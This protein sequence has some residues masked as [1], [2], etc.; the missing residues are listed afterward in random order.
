MVSG[1]GE[2]LADHCYESSAV[3]YYIYFLGKT[4]MMELFNA[5]QYAKGFPFNVTV[6]TLCT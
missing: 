1:V 3:S 4:V 5:I 6:P 2:I